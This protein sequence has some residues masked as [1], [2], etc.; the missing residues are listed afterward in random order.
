MVAIDSGLMAI[1]LRGVEV[2]QSGPSGG[3]ADGDRH[4]QSQ[5]AVVAKN[6][7]VYFY[8]CLFCYRPQRKSAE[9]QYLCA[10]VHHQS[11]KD[12]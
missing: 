9:L 11:V 8:I 5:A 7:I 2:F 4:S 1:H 12:P 6:V 10:A 3:P